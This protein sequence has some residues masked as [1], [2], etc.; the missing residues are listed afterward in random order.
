LKGYQEMSGEVFKSY[1]VKEAT[2]LT[3]EVDA[4][5]EEIAINGFTIVGGVVKE[6]EL[7]DM[8][9]RVDE[10]YQRQ[11]TEVGGAGSLDLINDEFVARCLLAYD[12]LFLHLAMRPKIT[13]ILERL[14]GDYFILQQQNAIINSPVKQNYQVSWHRDLSY[15][16]FVVTRPLAISALVCVDDFSEL[17]GGTY[18]LPASHKVEKF[19][20][21]GFVQKHEKAI[22]AKAGSALV[23]DS[24]LFHRG[25]INKSTNIRRGVNHMYALPF[26]KQQ[27]DMPKMLGG[28]YSDDAFL[29]K[30]LGYESAVETSVVSWRSKRLEKAER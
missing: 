5:V 1:G 25:G 3:S 10:V 20:S 29:S 26:V 11:A 2:L 14:L 15:Q 16:H 8:R 4:H 22:I 23:F 27:I 17:T 28:K 6:S 13:S 24:M 21:Q 9:Q 30:F 19:P 7:A 12:E 18:V